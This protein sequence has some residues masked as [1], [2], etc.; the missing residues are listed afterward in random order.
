TEGTCSLRVGLALGDVLPVEVG[1]QVD[2]VGVVQQE[3][4]VAADGQA[5]AVTDGRGAVDVRRPAGGV[6]PTGGIGPALRV[7][8]SGVHRAAPL[9]Q[10]GGEL[11]W[12]WV[13]A[14]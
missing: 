8:G 5:V 10:W 13:L 12:S 14:R 11:R 7:R 3:R 9:S 6:E 1:E 4:A 2:Q